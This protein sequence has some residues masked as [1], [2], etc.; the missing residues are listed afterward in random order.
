M[1]GVNRTLALKRDVVSELTPEELGA[2]AAGTQVTRTCAFL[3]FAPCYVLLS[4]L[5]GCL[6]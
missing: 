2:V 1:R 3:T 6:P 5:E 4:V